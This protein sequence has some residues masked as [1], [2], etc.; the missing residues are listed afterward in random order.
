ARIGEP[1]CP[2]CGRPIAGQSVEQ[3]ADRVLELPEGT[4]FQVLAPLVRGR[5]GEHREGLDHVRGEGFARVAVDGT[6]DLVDEVPPLHKKRNHTIEVVVDRL[7]M[8]DDLRRRLTESLE[9]A[10]KLAD[11]LVRV[12]EVGGEGRSWLY[13]ERFA[14]PEHGASLPEMAPR[15]FS[16]N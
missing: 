9:T 15:I 4:R 12:E 2:V 8:R 10:T 3:I 5:K 16:F 7:V 1:H 13:S 11:G 14:C 6:V